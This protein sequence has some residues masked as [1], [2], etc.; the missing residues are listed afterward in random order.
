[1][2]VCQ[3]RLPLFEGELIDLLRLVIDRK[4]GTNDIP[5]TDV[6]TQVSSYLRQQ[7]EFDLEQ[8]GDLVLGVARLLLL[9]SSHLLARPVDPDEVEDRLSLDPTVD[10]SDLV[11]TASELRRYEGWDCV[12]P[13]ESG[14][15]FERRLEP[16][17]ASMLRRAWQEL[18]ARQGQ[19][20]NPVVLPAF[21]RLEVALSGLVRRLKQASRLSLRSLLRGSTRND[22]V[23]YFLA[24]LELT[25][26][27][28]VVPSQAEQFGDISLEYVQRS[29][30]AA[31]R[32]G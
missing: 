20:S 18:K 17:D 30:E 22:A 1:M 26:R 28:Q 6:A 24:V 19:N 25:R 23:V 13:V 14:V 8:V 4:L 5:M 32:A 9:K 15:A 31:S 12:A 27:R 29:P 7:D 16:R 2:P 11:R 3:L 10:R 21:V